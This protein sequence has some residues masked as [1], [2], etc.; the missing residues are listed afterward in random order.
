MA[1]IPGKTTQPRRLAPHTRSSQRP[2]NGMEQRNRQSS[3][4]SLILWPLSCPPD[5]SV[6]L[7]TGRCV[8]EPGDRPR[9]V[10]SGPHSVL[11][12]A[13]EIRSALSSSA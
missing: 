3:A 13:F 11:L 10:D 7:S 8:A 12:L 2:Q 1:E 4:T 9:G 6:V 5:L